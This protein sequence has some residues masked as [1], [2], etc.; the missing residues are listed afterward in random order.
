MEIVFNAIEV[1]IL[2]RIA[3][4]VGI[5]GLEEHTI[6][7]EIVLPV[8]IIVNREE[9]LTF[10]GRFGGPGAAEE[11]DI[12]LG[13]KASEECAEGV[14]ID[15]ICFVIRAWFL[16]S[17][18]IG[19]PAIGFP[20]ETGEAGGG[21]GGAG[22]GAEENG[23][24]EVFDLRAMTEGMDVEAAGDRFLPDGEEA[25]AGPGGGAELKRFHFTAERFA[26]GEADDAEVAVGLIGLAG[27]DALE[28]AVERARFVLV[29]ILVGF[30]EWREDGDA[31]GGELFNGEV[32]GF[33][34]VGLNGDEAGGNLCGF[35]GGGGI[36]VVNG[37]QGSEG[38]GAQFA[39]NSDSNS[40]EGGLHF[41]GGAVL[42]LDEDGGLF[43][44]EREA[45]YGRE[46]KGT[47][48]HDL[49][50]LESLRFPWHT[51]DELF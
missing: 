5:G 48:A 49:T 24:I 13:A 12:A 27:H 8:A 4:V 40:G 37:E 42:G 47:N 15:K 19:C 33:A 30:E 21:G 29:G 50:I 32:A 39:V 20:T 14:A 45:N 26:G 46:E 17:I 23:G 51:H 43:G 16:E 11:K 18:W 2:L 9:Q 3:D 25:D 7:A 31:D 36:P 22:S 44:E 10:R 34:I 6:G 35:G 28:E 41:R 38:D 1:K